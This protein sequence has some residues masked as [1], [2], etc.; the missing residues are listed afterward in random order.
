ME[1]K[2]LQITEKAT[3]DVVL[4]GVGDEDIRREVLDTE[5][6]LSRSLFEIVSFIKSKETVRHSTKNSWNVSAVSLIKRQKK[7]S[8]NVEDNIYL[9]SALKSCFIHSK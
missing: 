4:A 3:K 8:F 5:D 1:R 2:I 9:A 7:Q 6:V